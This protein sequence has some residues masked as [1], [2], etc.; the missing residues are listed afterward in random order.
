V[1]PEAGGELAGVPAGIHQM[2]GPPMSYVAVVGGSGAVAEVTYRTFERMGTREAMEE[3]YKRFVEALAGALYQAA[4]S[5]YYPLLMWR[6]RPEYVGHPRRQGEWHL[7]CRLGTS[8]PLPDE[9]WR[10]WTLE[11]DWRSDE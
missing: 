10:K 4:G 7:Y 9:F 6:V 8:P 5:R 3:V 1:E 2:D 11:L